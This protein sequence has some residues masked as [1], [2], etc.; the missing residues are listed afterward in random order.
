MRNLYNED[1]ED[2]NDE[3]DETESE[4]LSDVRFFNQGY[5]QMLRLKCLLKKTSKLQNIRKGENEFR[6][7]FSEVSFCISNPVGRGGSN[8]YKYRLNFVLALS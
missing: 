4:T 1:E 2:E 7:V 6:L 5:S 3:M 8:K